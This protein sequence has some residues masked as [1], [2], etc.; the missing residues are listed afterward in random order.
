MKLK[1]LSIEHLWVIT[2]LGI[3]FTYVSSMPIDQ[4]DFWHYIKT[5]MITFHT[6]KIVDKEI[7]T[8]SA[9]NTPYIN[10]HWASQIYYFLLYK[11]GGIQLLAFSHAVIITVVFTF[12]F[13]LAFQYSSNLRIASLTTLISLALSVTNFALR[14][15]EFSMLFFSLVFYCLRA[16]KFAYIP[17]LFVLWA[18]F[19]GAFIVGLLLLVVELL[20]NFKPR[21]FIVLLFSLLATL[22]TPWGLKIYQTILNVESENFANLVSE[23]YPPTIHEPA[24]LVFFCAL[25]G[26][27]ALKN[28]E[29]SALTKEE[30]LM[31]LPFT[32][33]ALHS[34][35]A[36]VWWAI[37]TVPIFAT[38]LK[39]LSFDKIVDKKNISTSST[40][41]WLVNLIFVLLF[42]CYIVGCLPWF[43]TNNPLV[44]KAKRDLI[45]SNTP[46]ELTDELVKCSTCQ[47]VFNN[48]AWGS[49]F[50][51]ALHDNQKIFLSPWLSVFP[52]NILSDYLA[53]SRGDALWGELLDKYKVDTLAI[54]KEEQKLLLPLVEK[55]KLWK[56]V[57]ENHEGVIF[58]RNEI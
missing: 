41:N 49:Y 45:A 51:W 19:H 35:R 9:Q 39:N 53:V 36:I 2:I 24:G 16:N 40:N 32:F 14:P 58:T 12:V 3:C 22:L 18:N 8:F 31:I 30:I 23:W 55:S 47:K 54:S 44:P 13:I 56:K 15:Q 43:K 46:V 48:F 37:V 11:L 17:L 34:Q 52:K 25:L 4:Y 1:N 42:F 20:I 50:M 38:C 26:L 21:Y 10:L 5:G 27:F 29:K 33:L 57:F 7:F 6:H 28:I